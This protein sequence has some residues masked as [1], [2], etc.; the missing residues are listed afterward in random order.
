MSKS[1]FSKPSGKEERVITV[2]LWKTGLHGKNVGINQQEIY[3]AKS[4]QFTRDMN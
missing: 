1:Y 2:D 3:M 4:N